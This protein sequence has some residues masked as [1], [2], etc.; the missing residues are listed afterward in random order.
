MLKQTSPL[1]PISADR[2]CDETLSLT[3]NFH[4]L[5]LHQQTHCADGNTAADGKVLEP[6]RSEYCSEEIDP[7][8]TAPET[9]FNKQQSQAL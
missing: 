2:E 7:P 9:C 6:S 1:I 4:F 8:P 3:F 5:V